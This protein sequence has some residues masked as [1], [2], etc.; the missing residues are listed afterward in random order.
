MIGISAFGGYVPRM[1]MPREE[2]AKANAWLNPG[3]RAH[4]KGERSLAQWDEDAVTMAVEAARD[5]LYA[6]NGI[7]VDAVFLASTTLPF[8][9]RLNAGIVAGALG[10][11]A[12]LAAMDVTSSQRAGVSALSAAIDATRAGR[13][14]SVLVTAAE[15]RKA[16]PGSVAEMTLGDGG[17]AFVVSDRNVIAEFVGGVS[18][19]VDFVDHYRA[20]G[21]DFDYDWEERW[22]RDEGYMK[23]VPPVL[24]RCLSEHGIKGPEVAHFIFQAPGDIAAKLAKGLG[25]ES[26][27][28]ADNLQSRCGDVGS[29]HP[30]LLLSH[31]LERARPGEIILV[32]AFGQGVEAML[33]RV[34]DT[35]GS[36]RPRYG[37][38]GYLG[39]RAEER[40]Y[41]K[42]PIF[43][44]VMPYDKGMRAEFDRKATLS[45]MYRRRDFL[46]AFV[47]GQCTKCG[48]VQ[49]PRT[50]ACAECG[51]F[52]SQEPHAFA[53]EK[54]K[55][56]S[57]SADYLAYTV[58]PPNHF[59]MVEF[60]SGGRLMVDM[61]D[62]KPGDVD[63]GTEVRMVFRIK[64]FDD[65][66]NF[67]RYF[68][69]ATPTP[70]AA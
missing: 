9:D 34:T 21:A 22:I 49:I 64:D 61:T 1:R 65:S 50:R 60:A 7:G 5:C 38:T 27:R 24:Q 23:L 2:I 32:A 31:V 14:A 30:L 35:I 70:K 13:H 66:R 40:Q 11:P 56:V 42:L 59:G 62:V 57:W 44:R 4:A 25:I 6:H 19:T 48:T 63:T 54:G 15:R 41:M 36:A 46:E 52:D 51:S 10:L 55:V 17:A 8:A 3:L 53:N 68:W 16:V 28:V 43:N 20:A 29:A 47:G 26:D 39:Q 18:E 67:R 69:K 58:S 45:M 12:R 37:V 33:L